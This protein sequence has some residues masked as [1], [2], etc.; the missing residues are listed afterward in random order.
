VEIINMTPK[1]SVAF[2]LVNSDVIPVEELN[3]P[4][5]SHVTEVQVSDS[6][7]TISA[8]L[9]RR[10]KNAFVTAYLREP[11]YK[12]DSIT[13]K[14]MIKTDGS[15]TQRGDTY[16]ISQSHSLL[17]N[18]KNF[19]LRIILPEGYGITEEGVSPKPTRFTSD[20]RKI[21]L[22]WEFGA[23]IPTELREFRV[24]LLFEKL[25]KEQ[26]SI[27]VQ[28][29]DV[30]QEMGSN[31]LPYLIIAVLVLMLIPLGRRYL[32]E[33]GFTIGDY[34]VKR[35][36]IQNKI[37]ILREDEQAILK[38]VVENDGIDQREIQRVTGFS[39]TKVS[40][41]LSELEKRGAITKEQIGRRNRIYL[42]EKMKEGQ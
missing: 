30:E 9:D 4:F 25:I 38:L 27:F 24:L 1:E 12:D 3:Y 42:A 23:P 19:R 31:T 29:R 36:I 37:D 2:T 5:S 34:F 8:V 21:I 16:I 28:E 17:A 6:Q 41:I 13:L 10:D 32:R 14:Y 33:E 39:K 11:L 20:G 18:V 7:G 40:K 15:L 26:P 22:V 35:R